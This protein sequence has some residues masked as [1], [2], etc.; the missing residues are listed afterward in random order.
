MLSVKAMRERFQLSGTTTMLTVARLVRRKGIDTVLEAL[1]HVH[2]DMKNV[3]YLIVG[4]GP[5]RAKLEEQ[6]RGLGLNHVVHFLGAV[7]EA[8]LPTLYALSDVFVLTPHASADSRDPEGFGIVYLEANAFGKPVVA[9]RTG[10]VPEAVQNGVT[11]MLVPPDN[12]QALAEALS[13]LLKDAALR[14]RLGTS[15][16]QYVR[17]HCQWSQRIQPLLMRLE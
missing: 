1:A 15:G 12:P 10:G 6:A 14:S 2:Q 5:E 4:D 17:E 8:L 11:G 7:D 16:Q 3:G 13:T 9:S